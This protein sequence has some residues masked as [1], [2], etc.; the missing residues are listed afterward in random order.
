MKNLDGLFRQYRR[1][2]VDL[3]IYSH[4]D[5]DKVADSFGARPRAFLGSQMLEEV[6][7]AKLTK[8]AAALQI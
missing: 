3:N 8:L 5:V 1:K 4:K 2:S 7:R 6:C